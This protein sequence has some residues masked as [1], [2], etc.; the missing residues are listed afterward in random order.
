MSD[1]ITLL[2][3]LIVVMVLA[4]FVASVLMRVIIY[5]LGLGMAGFFLGGPPGFVIGCIIGGI[6]GIR[7]LF[8]K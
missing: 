5:M 1:L 4:R 3:I 8:A 7:S 2:L 6:L